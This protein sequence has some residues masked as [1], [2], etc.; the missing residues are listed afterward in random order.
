MLAR[1]FAHN[2]LANTECEA[3]LEDWD[4]ALG[5]LAMARRRERDK[6][7]DLMSSMKLTRMRYLPFLKTKGRNRLRNYL[8]FF[9]CHY[10]L[11]YSRHLWQYQ[12]RY[13]IIFCDIGWRHINKFGIK[14][15]TL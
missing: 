6:G 11:I 10:F 13:R 14:I 3:Y 5:G 1:I 9:A 7:F 4:V 2:P 12:T 8:F 15:L